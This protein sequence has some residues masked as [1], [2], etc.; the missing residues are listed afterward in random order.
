MIFPPVRQGKSNCYPYQFRWPSE[1][2]SH[3]NCLGALKV[4]LIPAKAPVTDKTCRKNTVT[5]LPA[6]TH[7]SYKVSALR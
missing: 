5:S 6:L 7:T 2:N 3:T 1:L 4:S